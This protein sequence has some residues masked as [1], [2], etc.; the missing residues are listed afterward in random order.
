MKCLYHKFAC[1]L[2]VIFVYI[3]C[4]GRLHAQTYLWHSDTLNYILDYDNVMYEYDFK[5]G[6]VSELFRIKQSRFDDIFTFDFTS[7]LRG[8]YAFEFSPDKKDVYFVNREAGL[9]KYNIANDSLSF[10]IDLTPE[11]EP[12]NYFEYSQILDINFISDSIIYTSGGTYSEYNIKT[13]TYRRIRQPANYTVFFETREQELAS[14]SVVH[15][16]G[17]YIY[18]PL[19]RPYKLMILDLDNPDNNTLFTDLSSFSDLGI[20]VNNLISVQNDCDSVD[21]YLLTYDETPVGFQKG[22]YKIDPV[23]GSWS[24]AYP[25]FPFGFYFDMQ[26]VKHYND[27]SYDA[28]QRHIDL[29]IDNSTALGQDYASP[30]QCKYAHTAISDTDVLIRNDYPLDS[31]VIQI[32]GAVDD[33][34]LIVASGSYDVISYSKS[35][36]VIRNTGST[37]NDDFVAAIRNTVYTHHNAGKDSEVKILVTPYYGGIAG[38][39]A[40]TTIRFTDPLPNAGNDYTLVGC[41]DSPPIY[42][43]STLASGVDTGG[44]FLY[45]DRTVDSVYFL[46]IG[47]DTVSY[48]T[49]QGVCSDT[50]RI[51]IEVFERPAFTDLQD[52]VLCSDQTLTVDLSSLSGDISWNDTNT[53]KHR[54]FDQQGVYVYEI[55]SDKGCISSDTFRLVYLPA[56]THNATDTIVCPDR[57]FVNHG[58]EYTQPGIYADTLTNY[59]G[60]DSIITTLRLSFHSA[61]PLTVEGNHG[62]CLG[63]PTTLTVPDEY[64]NL[65]LDGI[66]V[67][68]HFTITQPGMYILQ[69]IDKHGCNTGTDLNIDT[70]PTPVIATKDLTDTIYTHGLALPVQYLSQVSEYQWQPD[71]G[72]LDCVICP[73]PVLVS[74]SPGIYSIVATNEYGCQSSAVIHVTFKEATIF[75]PNVISNKPQNA[76]NGVF[77]V[78]GN[79]AS[80][81][82]IVVYD[83]WGNMVFQNRNAR[84]NDIDDGWNPQGSIVPGV[85]V[86]IIGFNEGGKEKMMH[87]S[88]TV[89][90]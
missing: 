63:S 77:Y 76:E 34:E 35:H 38:L 26:K 44:V 18:I 71:D 57:P 19:R 37:T 41:V 72:S 49:N 3:S 64:S 74:E 52:T 42:L 22:W 84:S 2:L 53:D 17:K 78:K 79:Y 39:D 24:F 69:G 32:S 40:V 15:Y 90:E 81:Y 61:V 89:L 31:L 82:S 66:P 50:A 86:Y 67:D 62:I 68:N 1:T 73:Y 55:W 11:K 65:S 10:L 16:K 87:G 75:I 33:R 85:Y 59:L 25:K 80:F 7:W 70:F 48:I 8:I 9:F 5:S 47:V 23:S 83:R 45:H 13:N 14:L 88:V 43:A 28:C 27:I 54:V 46:S 58:I 60:C 30:Y 20:L 12:G 21:L 51:S 6:N 36:K 4:I 29:D 56:V